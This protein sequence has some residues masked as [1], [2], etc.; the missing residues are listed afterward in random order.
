MRVVF[1]GTPS[2]AVPSLQAIAT[3][4]EFELVLVVTGPDKPR[5]GKHADAEPTAVKSAAIALGLPVYETDDVSDPLFEEKVSQC[6]ADVIVVAAFRILPPSVYTK[7]RLGAFNLHASLLPAYRGA[8]PIN[9]AIIRGERE[10]GVTTFFLQ[11]RV[12]T[13]NIILKAK[14]AIGPDENAFELAERLSRIGADTVVETLRLI[15]TGDAAV[16]K[17]DDA[18]ATKAPKLTRENSRIVWS[19]PVSAIHNFIRGL[20]LKPAAWTMMEGKTMKIF[21]ARPS[22]FSEDAPAGPGTVMVGDGRFCVR[23]SDGWI[24]LLSL[25]LEGRKPMEAGEFLRGYR[26]ADAPVVLR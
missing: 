4:H 6:L 12:D 24:E 17:Q 2:F 1:M 16:S 14:T 25:Q 20:A 26:Q 19:Q 15:S 13:G 22:A 21:S 5:R 3:H 9:W 23:C 8:A 11:D 10:T 7:A 18:L